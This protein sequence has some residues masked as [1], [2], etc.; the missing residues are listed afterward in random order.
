MKLVALLAAGHQRG[1]AAAREKDQQSE[2]RGFPDGAHESRHSAAQ[3]S[4]EN[5][6]GSNAGVEERLLCAVGDVRQ[7]AGRAGRG[8]FA[9]A[10][11]AVRSCSKG[12]TSVVRQRG[13]EPAHSPNKSICGEFA[14]GKG[15]SL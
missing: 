11:G 6:Q 14:V 10:R 9:T 7:V 4:E 5:D 15:F 1:E 8:P 12:L 13:E 2:K 3:G